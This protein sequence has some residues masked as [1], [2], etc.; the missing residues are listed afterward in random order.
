MENSG[1]WWRMVGKGRHLTF[2]VPKVVIMHQIIQ[3]RLEHIAQ[4]LLVLGGGVA[5]V[6]VGVGGIGGGGGGV[7]GVGSGG[8]LLV[9]LLWVVG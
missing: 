7:E 3:P 5:G 4:H 6:G 2:F 1:Q 9:L 8:V